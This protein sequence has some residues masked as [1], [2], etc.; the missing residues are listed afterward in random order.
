MAPEPNRKK[1]T[2]PWSKKPAALIGATHVDPRLGEVRGANSV[3]DFVP[4]VPWRLFHYP[5]PFVI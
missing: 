2:T 4:F 1:T 5:L 3:L